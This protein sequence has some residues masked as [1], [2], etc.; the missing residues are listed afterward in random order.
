MRGDTRDSGSKSLLA[1]SPNPTPH[2]R[3]RGYKNQFPFTFLLFYRH[4]HR[5]EV[6]LLVRLVCMLCRT[7]NKTKAVQ[8]S[9]PSKWRQPLF[10]S[11]FRNTQLLKEGTRPAGGPAWALTLTHWARFPAH[12]CHPGL[13]PQKAMPICPLKILVCSVH[14]NLSQQWVGQ[15]PKS[16]HGEP[17]FVHAAL[18]WPSHGLGAKNFLAHHVVTTGTS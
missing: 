16:F 3:T 17:P 13:A 2:P 18:W 6:E 4:P 12:Q 15:N 9:S 5:R 14:D 8:Q 7:Q 1:Y 11:C 10:G